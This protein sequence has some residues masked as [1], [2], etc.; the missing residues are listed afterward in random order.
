M[1]SGQVISSQER[2]HDTDSTVLL[3][4]AEVL[5]IDDSRPERVGGAQNG[6]VPV[7]NPVSHGVLDRDPDQ[8]MVDRLAWE[9]G[10]LFNPFERLSR[11]ERTRGF[12]H[13]RYKEFLKNLSGGAEIE[14]FDQL[15]R[16]LS[17]GLVAAVSDCRVNQNIGVK[18]N[19]SGHA[20]LR[21]SMFFCR[22][23]PEIDGSIAA[24]APAR[25]APGPH[26]GP[27]L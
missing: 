9:G 8:L 23:G 5:G 18:E 2:I 13:H 22:G 24:T 15:Q 12:F 4:I 1:F 16:P 27:R 7:G 19:V 3:S 20:G 26:V 17:F 14:R 10:P 21:V 11:R 25:G 6:A